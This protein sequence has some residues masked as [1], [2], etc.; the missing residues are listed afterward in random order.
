MDAKRKRI[1]KADAERIT[2]ASQDLKALYE[3]T[4]QYKS[5][6]ALLENCIDRL[7][8]LKVFYAAHPGY[9][10]KNLKIPYGARE[11][12]RTFSDA[13]V[14]YTYARKPK[15]KSDPAD[16]FWAVPLAVFELVIDRADWLE[17]EQKT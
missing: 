3:K 14:I 1:T 15:S 12:R 10:D 16:K 8:V 4:K 7:G 17:A 2:R 9:M 11:W 13:K 6:H 5:T